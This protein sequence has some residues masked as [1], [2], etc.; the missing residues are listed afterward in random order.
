VVGLRVVVGEADSY[1]AL[2]ND[3]QKNKDKGRSRFPEG[4]PERKARTTGKA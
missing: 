2:R 4:T 3:S 1:A